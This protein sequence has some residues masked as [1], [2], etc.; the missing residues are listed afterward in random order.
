MSSMSC[1][2]VAALAAI[3]AGAALALPGAASAKTVRFKM[4][5]HAAHP[6]APPDYVVKA[7]DCKVRGTLGSPIASAP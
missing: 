1:R 3:A 6:A 4:T 2:T 5:E 7:S